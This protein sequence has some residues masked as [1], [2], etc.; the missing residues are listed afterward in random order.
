MKFYVRLFMMILLVVWGQLEGKAEN[1]VVNYDFE[2]D[3]GS[4][5][6]WGTA[7]GTSLGVDGT[8]HYAILHGENGVLYQRVAGV[9]PGSTY[10]CTMSIKS[11][12]VKQT[13]G[14]GFAVE[15]GSALTLPDFTIGATNLKSFCEGNGGTWTTLPATSV[16]ET[17]VTYTYNLLIPANATAIYVCL[18]TKGAVSDMQVT[19]VELKKVGA[20]NVSFLVKNKITGDPLENAEIDIA[21]FSNLLKTNVSGIASVEIVASG[22][23]YSFKVSRDWFKLYESEVTVGET[24]MTVT[25]ELDSIEEVKTVET[26][27]SKY[28]DNAT[29]YPLFGHFWSSGLAYSDVIADSISKTLDYIVGGGGL[30]NSS[31]VSDLLHQY[32]AAFQVIRYQGGWDIK[33]SL[34]GDQK[35]DLLYY[36]CGILSASISET[37]NTFILNTTPDNKG[38][39]LVASEDGNFT[40]WIRMGNEL[41][42][43]IS[44]SGSSYPVTVTVERGLDGT[45]A[46]SYAQ[47]TTVSAPLYSTIPVPGGNNANL[48]FFEPVFGPR[49]ADLLQ[50]A[51]AVAQSSGQDGIW[52]DILVGLL[53]AQN[54]VGGNYTL[55]NHEKEEIFSNADII[56]ATKDAMNDVYDGFFARMGYFPVIYG[57]N[58]LYSSTL[59]PGDRAYVM[60]KTEEHPRGLDGFC[61]ENSWGHMTDAVGSVDNDGN[62]VPTSDKFIIAGANQHYLEWYMGNQWIGNCKAIALLAEENL[63]N[64]PMTINAG[65]KNQ[66]FAADLTDEVRYNFNKYAY[67]SYLLCVNVTADSLISCRMG[68]SPQVVK[69][70]TTTINF[71]PFFYYPIGVPEQTYASSSFT[72]YRVGNSNLYARRFSNGIVLVNPF[73]TDM[74]SAINLSDIGEAGKIYVDPE[75]NNAEVTSVSLASRESK[76]LLIKETPTAIGDLPQQKD[77]RFEIY[78]VPATDVLYFN[79]SKVSSLDFNTI[80]V[81]ILNQ[82]GMLVKTVSV[83]SG[84]LNPSIQVGD[85]N[86][87]IYFVRLPEINLSAKF[88]KV[89]N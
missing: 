52:I 50:N 26:R 57:N 18:G 6:G 69:A 36:R 41:M 27:I 60:V 8:D 31:A 70:G 76:I 33:A 45:V 16:A 81:E 73:A 20:T 56:A 28:G 37:D 62:P 30:D 15:T 63:P 48:S 5:N 61:H 12:L 25:V 78:P 54:M 72:Q 17:D 49:K 13:T 23:P 68:I 19:S 75:N 43:I 51:L 29:P 80:R 24:D 82:T 47:G 7:S 59:T 66:W 40:T 46:Q 74:T 83:S 64:Q 32:D 89:G 4:F 21:G 88:F 77:D 3:G 14:Y 79:M 42:K 84:D 55:W 1:L 85:L 71:E 87:G 38:L 67:A 2:A 58:V 65:F 11:I 9:I 39:G 35:M 34:L 10:T 22:T 44:V 53:G 86:Q